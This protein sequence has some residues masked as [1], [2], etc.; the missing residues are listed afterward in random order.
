MPPLPSPT[1]TALLGR[2][3]K[4]ATTYR[5]GD[6]LILWNCLR[7][8]FIIVE[9]IGF[10]SSGKERWD[11]QEYIKRTYR[12]AEEIQNVL[13]TVD[14]E[15]EDLWAY[16]VNSSSAGPRLIQRP[17]EERRPTPEFLWAQRIDLSEIEITSLWFEPLGYGRGI[18]RGT[19]YDIYLA[20]VEPYLGVME[21][22]TKAFKAL[23]GLDLTYEVIAHIFVGDMLV[24]LMIV[25][26]ALAKLERAFMVHRDLLD[27][28]RL[29]VDHTGKIRFLD[30]HNLLQFAINQRAELEAQAQECHWDTI[31]FIFECEAVSGPSMGIIW[32][33]KTS[34]ITLAKTPSPEQLLFIA[35]PEY[36]L[37]NSV[38]IVA[39]GDKNGRKRQ[40]TTS[41]HQPKALSLG[42]SLL[43]PKQTKIRGVTPRSLDSKEEKSSPPRYTR[44]PPSYAMIELP[45]RVWAAS[46][47]NPDGDHATASIV[48]LE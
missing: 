48:E 45:V 15:N 26:A 27:D 11:G 2:I 16:L 9:E 29:V 20:F 43:T 13:H 7:R 37:P 38:C 33:R 12:L 24:G 34:R 30:V 44:P 6:L 46:E 18:W 28:Q 40:K 42:P 10:P 25:F 35:L 5:Q 36:K 23:R 14:F 39:E 31:R 3:P 21:R 1:I 22:E 19:E 47:E 17:P 4:D 8:K 41:K 32:F